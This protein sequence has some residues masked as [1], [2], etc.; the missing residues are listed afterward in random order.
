MSKSA[1]DDMTTVELV[2][3]LRNDANTYCSGFPENSAL[4][5][6]AANALEELEHRLA[7]AQYATWDHA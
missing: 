6:A 7:D 1:F 3:A 2:K 5:F 4:L